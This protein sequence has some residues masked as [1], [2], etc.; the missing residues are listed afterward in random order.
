M[1]TCCRERIELMA[2]GRS[3]AWKLAHAAA[4]KANAAGAGVFWPVFR[5]LVR[6]EVLTHAS[7]FL[8]RLQTELRAVVDSTQTELEIEDMNRQAVA[9][10]FARR[11]LLLP[12]DAQIR[13]AAVL[14]VTGEFETETLL[15]KE[16][17]KVAA[18][19]KLDVLANVIRAFESAKGDGIGVE[20]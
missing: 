12:H 16:V 2:E 3:R 4:E 9:R 18:G 17:F 13:V 15:A 14:G 10:D 11:F 8:L 7:A 5:A 1:N 19:V 6:T 20:C